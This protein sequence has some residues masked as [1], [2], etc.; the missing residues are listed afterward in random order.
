[1]STNTNEF[2]SPSVMDESTSVM[3]EQVDKFA[4][5]DLKDDLTGKGAGWCSLAAVDDRD[6][7]TLFN[8]VTTPEKLS[9]QIN[10]QIVLR[11]IYVE[12][13]QVTSEETGE[14]VNAPRI[15]LI[16]DKGNGYQSVGTGI[17]NAVK[18][19]IGIFG[20]PADWTMPHTVEVVNV[21]LPGGRHTFTLKIIK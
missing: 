18:R 2:Y 17:Y 13:V 8:A 20:D 19:I 14:M 21:S 6:K 10:K 9:D 11:H 7:V 5:I 15:V 12:V 3:L 4:C 16:D 1:M